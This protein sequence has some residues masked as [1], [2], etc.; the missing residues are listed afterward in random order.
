MR[1]F[2]NTLCAAAGATGVGLHSGEGATAVIRPAP[3]GTGVVF[4]RTDL[5][6]VLDDCLVP[7]RADFVSEKRLG[8]TL[9]NR[10]GVE[11]STVEHLLAALFLA[12]I[13]NAIV[14]LDGPEAPI[15][16]GSALRWMQLIG[17]CGIAPQKAPR[18]SLIVDRPFRVESGDRFVEVTPEDGRVLEVSVDYA[19]AALG[20]A[21]I[22]LDLD[23]DAATARL[24]RAR[25]FCRLEDVGAMR[26]AGLALGG[27]LD[28]AI[29]ADGGRILNEGG[30]RDPDEIVLHK[31]LDLVGD[32]A[33]VGARLVGR[34]RAHKS[35]HDLHTALARLLLR[36]SRLAARPIIPAPP[37]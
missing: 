32:M 35:G 36:E 1:G 16:D 4:R 3:A 19:D 10:V 21:S 8:V 33:L 29:V 11:V 34:I 14:E 25:T 22:R 5:E 37:A 17:T 20:R 12:G 18:L 31:A 6:R 28:N 13:D 2:Q 30:L 27:S 7:A 9:R 23:D 15:L 24:V 26:A